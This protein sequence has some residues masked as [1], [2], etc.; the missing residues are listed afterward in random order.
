MILGTAAYMSPEQAR[1][2]PVDKRADVWSFGVLLWE[3]LTGHS[4]FAGDTVTDVIAAVVTEEPD[5]DALPRATPRAVRRLLGRCLR[6]DPR[7]RLPDIGAARLELQE[8]RA[9]TI[10]EAGG[11]TGDAEE[12]ASERRRSRTRDWAWAAL[13]LALAGIA[14]V[15]VVQRLTTTPEPR[16]PA[17][18]VLDTP[19]D[20][21]F[22]LWNPVALSPDGRSLAF[23]ATSPGG[24]RQLWLRPL[25]S[26]EARPLPGTVGS[27]GGHFWSADSTTDRVRRR[28]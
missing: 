25:D 6:K 8:V 13:A 15:L 27:V 10:D 5:L 11:P 20:L 26:T 17:H 12:R 19:E 14:G 9:G 3:M 4:L 23:L 2:K 21:A 28:G 16:P 22:G 24:E 1:G 18:F 7:T